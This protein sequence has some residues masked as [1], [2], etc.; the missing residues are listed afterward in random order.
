MP[1][2]ALT[3]VLRDRCR[4][5]VHIAIHLAGFDAPLFYVFDRF[6]HGKIQKSAVAVS[7]TSFI[8]LPSKVDPFAL[9][10]FSPDWWFWLTATGVS[11]GCVTRWVVI[12]F[13]QIKSPMSF[14]VSNGS[15][16]L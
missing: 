16:L 9:R 8:R 2:R 6:L 7:D 14:L 10:S 1:G 5:A 15:A 13:Q 11:I 4:V 12:I 3:V